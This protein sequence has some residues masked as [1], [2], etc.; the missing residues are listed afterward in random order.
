[1]TLARRQRD[2]LCHLFLDVGALA[3][4]LCEGWQAQ[5][6][7][8]HL[9]VREHR[10][11]ALP[12]IGLKR[13]APHTEKIQNEVLD[14][15]G[16]DALVADLRRPAGLIGLV[17]RFANAAEY[18]IHHFDVLRAN[19]RDQTLSAADEA[20][21]WKVAGMLARATARRFGGRLV[22]A[23]DGHEEL[24]LGQGNR[25]VRL[26]GKPSEILYYLS[27]RTEHANV[28]LTGEPETLEAFHAAV[29]GL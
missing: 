9:W 15:R 1:M 19:G 25:P 3:P 24:A 28:E 26:A 17:D 21:L 13:F 10:I 22:V 16:F 20:E 2:H 8:A 23:P 7:A 4:T 12:G 5:D 14:T 6:L 11:D 29:K 27:G 18:T